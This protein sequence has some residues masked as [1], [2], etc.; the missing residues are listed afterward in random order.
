M[1]DIPEWFIDKYGQPYL[2]DNNYEYI[3]GG[4]INM[5]H[6]FVKTVIS[7]YPNE[8]QGLLD[9]DSE[10]KIK[11]FLNSTVHITQFINYYPD[12]GKL[13]TKTGYA[14]LEQN[15]QKLEETI[16]AM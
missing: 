7:Y 6:E 13:L 10:Q 14:L 1:D 9:L 2:Q 4:I 16:E 3:S 8:L 11:E 15:R 5:V 12:Q